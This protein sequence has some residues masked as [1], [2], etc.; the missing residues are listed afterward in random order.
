MALFMLEVS[1]WSV[2]LTKQLL[3]ARKDDLSKTT[4]LVFSVCLQ[5]KIL[6]PGN[7]N[8]ILDDTVHES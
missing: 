1:P 6:S 8:E 5:T 3:T 2:S 7:Q 4:A